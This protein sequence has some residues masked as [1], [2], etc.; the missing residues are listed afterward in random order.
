M[1]NFISINEYAEV[2]GVSTQTIWIIIVLSVT[3]LV[4]IFVLFITKSRLISLISSMISILFCSIVGIIPLWITVTTLLTCGIYTFY[5][6]S[7]SP[8]VPDGDSVI[9]YWDLY[10][11]RMKKAY[12]AK[13][14]YANTGFDDEVNRRINVMKNIN[15]GFTQTIA[16]EWLNRME[17]FTEMKNR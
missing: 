14:G 7:A 15:S 8:V 11:D 1:I 13:F 6:I 3:F 2:F 10:S 4:N 9:D 16:K 5:Y 17:R 12:E